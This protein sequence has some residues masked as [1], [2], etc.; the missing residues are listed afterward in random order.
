MRK[1]LVFGKF[2]PLH[3]GHQLLIDTALA[4]CDDVTILLYDSTP[5]G[6]YP[7]MPVEKR[8]GW[9]RELYPQVENLFSIPDLIRG[10]NSDSPEY[11]GEY[12]RQINDI[13]GEGYFHRV[14]TSEPN[15]TEFAS[16]LGAL[17]ALVDE[18]RTLV[19][20]SG[21]QIRANPYRYR[22][23]MDPLVYS[24]LIQ[25]VVF[26]G[27]ESTGK[28]TLAQTMAEL[29]KTRW[30]HE[31]GRELWE[32]QGL[33]GTFTDHLKMARRQYAREQAALRHSNRFLFCDTNAWT[34]LMWC[35]NTYG[36]VD[37]RLRR[38]AID[39][40]PEYIWIVCANDFDFVQ[41]GTRELVD[42]KAELFQTL[43]IQML[44]DLGVNFD[45]VGGS[46]DV[47]VEQVRE[48]LKI[49]SP[50]PA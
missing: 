44:R 5:A 24:S 1:G 36:V 25:K 47:R 3:R 8:L 37:A 29:E 10:D 49:A 17:H 11:A 14:F 13:F 22:G 18:A 4:E 2:M 27:T 12:A 7:A 48:I 46:L 42:G 9:I 39:T 40:I 38:L 32:S 26:V 45:Y 31:F 21:T 28:S 33:T 34:T 23:F 15:Y 50:V 6:D 30:T 16:E 20:I 19:P 41:D 35:I 43:Q